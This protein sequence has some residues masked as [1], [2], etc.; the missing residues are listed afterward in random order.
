MT[1]P[2]GPTPPAPAPP[3][4][5]SAPQHPSVSRDRQLL[6]VGLI[7][8]GAL[9]L[10]GS[11]G[12]SA[13][14]S[15]FFGVTL[16]LALGLVALTVARRTGNDW[17]MAAAFPAFGLALAVLWSGDWGGAAFL[18]SIGAGF[19]SLYVAARERWWAII[20]AGTLFTLALVA[21]GGD[22][23][24]GS[25]TLFFL[26]LALTFAVLW[27]LPHEPQAWAVFPAAALAVMALVVTT[28][29]GGWLLPLLLVAAGAYLLLRPA[30][31]TSNE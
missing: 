23:G 20:P 9:A 30:Q 7:V 1:D 12:V 24:T 17:V 25:G 14:L 16:F 27:R 5:P 28:T 13:A 3:P 21:A 15:T 10:L 26:G 8:I 4:P 29:A 11:L 22:R 18:A 31:R 6:A 19:L 2:T